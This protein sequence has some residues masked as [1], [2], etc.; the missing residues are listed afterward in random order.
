MYKTIAVISF[1]ILILVACSSTPVTDVNS[2][3]F[4]PPAGSRFIV[5][6]DINIDAHKTSAWFQGGKLKPYNQ[7]DL[8]YPNCKFELKSLSE[9]S[10]K[11]KPDIF[12]VTRVKQEEQV[13]DMTVPLRIAGASVG[14]GIGGGTR[15]GVGVG[16]G[17][18]FSIGAG[19]TSPVPYATI[20]YLRSEEQPEVFRVTC[21]HW[22]DP[23]DGQ[24]L[25]FGEIR[26]ALGDYITIEVG[27]PQK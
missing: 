15:S 9:K 11:V 20:F 6:R 21:M 1:T 3:Y 5:N 19:G 8:Y 12:L 7:L 18:G 10:R 22:E 4:V 26:Q 16:I 13:L 17:F 27:N 25:T 24:Y 23:A 14:I 2:P